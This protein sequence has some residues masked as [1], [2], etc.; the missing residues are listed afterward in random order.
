MKKLYIALAT[1]S[2]S[3]LYANEQIKVATHGKS[4]DEAN[5]S[6]QIDYVEFSFTDLLGNHKSI[7]RPLHYFEKDIHDGIAFDG[8]SVFGCSNVSES[9]MLL[10]P[11]LEAVTHLPWT[12][13]PTR[14]ARV[15]CDIYKDEDQPHEGD[16]R[17]I[18]KKTVSE[19]AELGYDFIVGPELEFYLFKRKDDARKPYD[20]TAYCAS[21]KTVHDDTMRPMFLTI[22]Q[23]VGIPVEKIHHEVG[24]GQY[25]ISIA[26]TNALKMA[27]FIVMAKHALQALVSDDSV[28]LTF[29]PKPFADHNGSGMHIHFSLW[30]KETSENIFYNAHDPHHLSETAKQFIAGVL[31]HAPALTLIFNPSINS[32][33]RLV[34]GCEAPIYV[35][36]G[37]KN[38]SAL[39]RL[40]HTGDH[41]NAMRAEVRSPDA[42][43]NPYLAFA[44]LLKAGLDGIANSRELP[45]IFNENLYTASPQALDEKGILT[46]PHSLEHAIVAFERSE[47]MSQLFGADAH[48]QFVQAKRKELREFNATIT[49]W[50]FERYY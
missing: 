2:L 20:T 8:S 37:Q 1:L 47:L 6:N 39:I 21:S 32:Y 3:A 25:E 33:K 4:Q 42:L 23:A 9:D 14:T 31:Y 45:A 27:D 34:S 7:I 35:C 48:A 13:A 29:M 43:C 22:L 16:P 36:C 49:D 18:L 46:L 30:D 44:G 19:T 10:K 41:A 12:N 15:T 17:Y 50:E 26:Y 24:P 11:D 28:S 5:K 40:P 38:R